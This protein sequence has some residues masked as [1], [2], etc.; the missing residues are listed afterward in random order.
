MPI[1]H[2]TDPEKVTIFMTHA[3][4]GQESLKKSYKQTDLVNIGKDL[5]LLP[6]QLKG[7]KKYITSIILQRCKD[8]GP[9]LEAILQQNVLEEF[10]MSKEPKPYHDCTL[11]ELIQE[12]ELEEI[13]SSGSRQDII[14]RLER[15][16]AGKGAY[17]DSTDD[18]IRGELTKS[19]LS[20]SG[21]R[22]DCLLRLY[23][24]EVRRLNKKI[25]ELSIQLG[26]KTKV[27]HHTKYRSS[28][29]KNNHAFV[30]SLGRGMVFGA[31]VGLAARIF[32]VQK[33]SSLKF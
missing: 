7:N 33:K 17:E 27:R 2:F 13:L 23:P 6:A 26:K 5:G 28:R 25:E 1:H 11:E 14:A 30:R 32:R 4:A 16:D 8:Y 10:G 24:F 22:E 19:G 20:S 15:L 12:A 31:G 21:T 29:T 18:W 3:R 9:E